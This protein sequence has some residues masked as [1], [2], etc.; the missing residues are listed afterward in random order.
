MVGEGG[1]EWGSV[2][3]RARHGGS[4]GVVHC[5]L[6]RTV[7]DVGMQSGKTKDGAVWPRL[8]RSEDDLRCLD[9]LLNLEWL[10]KWGRGGEGGSR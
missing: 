10:T 5:L 2:G 7:A 8:A 3:R 9:L 1:Q 4:A 6:S